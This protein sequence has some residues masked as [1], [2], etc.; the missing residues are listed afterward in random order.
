MITIYKNF[1]YGSWDRSS[2]QTN[3][4]DREIY[5]RVYLYS[6]YDSIFSHILKG[7]SKKIKWDNINNS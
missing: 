4:T 5:Q 6:S 7:D 2:K 1:Q 3:N